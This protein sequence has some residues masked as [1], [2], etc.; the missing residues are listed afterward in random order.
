MS[1]HSSLSSP[2]P[3]H[4]PD[5]NPDLAEI[6][7][8]LRSILREFVDADHPLPPQ[9]ELVNDLGMASIQ[10]MDMVTR[11]ED[12]FDIVM[13]VNAL[14]DVRTLDQLARQVVDTLH[15]SAV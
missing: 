3:G 11:I 4:Q 14:A 9:T 6:T 15:A 2:E 12:H 13:P 7:D 10:V 8:I 5:Q 1:V